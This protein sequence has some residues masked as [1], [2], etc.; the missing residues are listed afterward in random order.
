M[1]ESLELFFKPASV[2][3]IGASKNPD[4]LSNGIVKNL[5][6][7]GYDGRVYPINPKEKEIQGLKAYP[8][9]NEIPEK[10]DLVV[11][12]I[13]ASKTID[14]VKDC[15]KAGVK[16][17]VIINDEA[18]RVA[19]I[20]RRMLTFARQYKPE[21]TQV[22]INDILADTLALR[23][24]ELETSNIKVATKLDP[25]LPITIADGGQLQQVFLNLIVDAEK[26]MKSAHGKGKLSIKTETVNGT[27]RISFRDNGPGITRENLEKIFDPFFTTREVGQG[28]GLGVSV[29]HGIITEH[30]FRGRIPQYNITILIDQDNC[31][32]CSFKNYTKL[33]VNLC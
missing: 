8:H 20:I 3:V 10:I 28:T 31:I 5:V 4:K 29:C 2:A 15:G 21:Q 17:L 13:P 7:Y 11:T 14:V 33:I 9:L 32:R 24:Y 19:S 18:K 26:E 23:A 25:D 27:I 22:N 16:N 12:A 6:A 1:R 30:L